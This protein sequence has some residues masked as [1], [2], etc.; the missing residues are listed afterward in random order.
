MKSAK[1]AREMAINLQSLM[2]G[3]LAWADGMC[4]GG[5]TGGD[6]EYETDKGE[7]GIPAP[8]NR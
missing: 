6:S 1:S 3:K 8:C 4:K 7:L 5:V 2:A